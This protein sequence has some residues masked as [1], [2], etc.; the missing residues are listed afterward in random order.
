MISME[1]GERMTTATQK[2][3][4]VKQVLVKKKRRHN[5]YSDS[6]DT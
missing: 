2:R 6:D 5:K 4:M 3:N 1:T